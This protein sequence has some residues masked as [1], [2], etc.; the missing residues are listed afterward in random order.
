MGLQ[1]VSV[2]ELQSAEGGSWSGGYWAGVGAVA[3]T[4]AGAVIGCG[5]LPVVAVCAIVGTQV[6]NSFGDAIARE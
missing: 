6:G 3:G 2:G 1:E 4:V 5:L